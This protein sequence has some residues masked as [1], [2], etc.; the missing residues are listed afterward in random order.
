[1]LECMTHRT[2]AALYIR[3]VGRAVGCIIKCGTCIP[4]CYELSEFV[5]YDCNLSCTALQYGVV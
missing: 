3:C 1:M 5:E 2:C 4:L